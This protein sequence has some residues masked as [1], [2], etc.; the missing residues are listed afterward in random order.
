MSGPNQ[1]VGA[2]SEL[3]PIPTSSLNPPPEWLR[4][5]SADLNC[6]RKKSSAGYWDQPR[7]QS[8]RALPVTARSP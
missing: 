7:I 5:P 6:A 8:H 2:V 4:G 3:P 1:P